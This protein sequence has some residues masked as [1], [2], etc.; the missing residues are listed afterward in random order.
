ML[1]R[2]T[3]FPVAVGSD[4]LLAIAASLDGLANGLVASRGGAA[5][6]VWAGSGLLGVRP[7]TV[8]LSYNFPSANGRGEVATTAAT[9]G[10]GSYG[11]SSN[12][13]LVT[14]AGP[15]FLVLAGISDAG[16]D[17]IQ[18]QITSR[19]SLNDNT[20]CAYLAG[21]RGPVSWVDRT[22]IFVVDRDAFNELFVP[23]DTVLPGITGAYIFDQNF[24]LDNTGVLT[25]VVAQG[26]NR[27]V[28]R[29]TVAGLFERLAGA[30]D[31][32]DGLSVTQANLVAVSPNGHL[33]YL[34]RTPSRQYVAL[35]RLGE[36]VRRLPVDDLRQVFD[37][38]TPGEVLYFGVGDAGLGLYGWNGSHA[39]T[40][41]VVGRLTPGEDPI[42]DLVGAS[43]GAGQDVLVHASTSRQDLVVYRATPNPAVLIESGA[44]TL[45]SAGL[46][47]D[48]LIPGARQ[49]P[50]LLRTLSTRS[51]AIEVGTI[52]GSPAT[53][54][55]A[56]GDRLPEGGRY[57]GSFLQRIADGDLLL[58]TSNSLQRINGTTSRSVMRFPY[59]IDNGTLWGPALAAANRQGVTAVLTYTSFPSSRLLLVDNGVA[60]LIADVGGGDP[61]YRTASPS[62]GSFAATRQLWVDDQGSVIALMDVTG[63]PAGIFAFAQG[64]WRPLLIVGSKVGNDT[65]PAVDFLRVVENQVYARYSSAGNTWSIAA[66]TDNGWT[67]RFGRGDVTP[68]GNS[69]NNPGYFDV[70]ADGQVAMAFS[71]AGMVG[72]GVQ[73]PGEDLRA[74]MLGNLSTEDGDLFITVES[75]DVRDDGRIYFT[76]FT[77]GDRWVAYVA[78]PVQ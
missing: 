66:Q 39:R 73:R 35:Q 23:G 5:P 71:S 40:L 11:T 77:T 9:G 4:G 7:G 15:R 32:V 17:L 48:S 12:I 51:G 75:V 63:G 26:G 53:A 58:A 24:V 29:R 1:L 42:T 8:L 54:L 28:F 49:G 68:T 34:I 61:Q 47:F 21:Y 14:R 36:A 55:V 25:F 43:F 70:F 45:G 76:G 67:R 64:Q 60:R 74:V 46:A 16:V 27:H 33:A 59:P 78:E 44:R 13:V 57:D 10:L 72:L 62:G 3:A 52:P 2:S 56:L 31:R 50:P 69:A 19:F 37:V 30:G 38:S 41:A 6:E 20:Q 65:V 22:G 18:P